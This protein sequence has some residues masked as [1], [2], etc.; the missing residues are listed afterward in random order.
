MRKIF[1]ITAMVLWMASYS[2]CADISELVDQYQHATDLQKQELEKSFLGKKISARGTVENVGEYN[3]FDINTDTGESY[4]RVITRQQ[5]TFGKT[6]YQV[7][8]MYKDKDAVRDISRGQMLE[9]EGTLINLVDERLQ[10]SVWIYEDALTQKDRE[11]FQ[12]ES[13][14]SNL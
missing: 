2:Y 1:L 3:F 5:D 9:L 10:I 12:L 14:K 7:I 11:L 13:T 6:P 8:F 4:Y